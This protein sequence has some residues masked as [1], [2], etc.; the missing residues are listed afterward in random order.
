MAVLY[1]ILYPFVKASTRRTVVGTVFRFFSGLFAF[2]L[3]PLWSCKR[4]NA[5]PVSDGEGEVLV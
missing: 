4:V 3:N 5:L 1:V 2:V